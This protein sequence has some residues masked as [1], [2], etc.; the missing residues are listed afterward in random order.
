M[1]SEQDGGTFKATVNFQPYF[2][3]GVKQGTHAVVEGYL[4]RR[5]E[6]RFASVECVDKEDLDLAN[7]LS[8][9]TSVYICMR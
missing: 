4:R 2:M 3:I 7:H 1:C 5:F 9:I 6:G 8:G